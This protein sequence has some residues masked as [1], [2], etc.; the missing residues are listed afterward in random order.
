MTPAI[1]E[2]TVARRGVAGVLAAA[3]ITTLESLALERRRL[4]WLAGRVAAKRAV[5]SLCRRR[6]QRVP[7]YSAIET[8]NDATGA[9]HFTI[10]GQPELAERLSVSIAHTDGTAVAA[11]AELAASGTVG[12]DI[13]STRPLDLALVRRVLT[14]I[15]I[16]QLEWVAAEHPSPIAMWT[17]K[18]AALK[19]ARHLCSALRDIELD[20]R[21]ARTLGAR[22]VG[23]HV[24][25]H[26]IIVRHRVVGPFTVA[27]ALC[28]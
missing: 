6:A 7:A 8:R 11:V 17:A 25:D 10:H 12:V 18:E 19:A 27:I 21:H 20:W 22:V 15:E 26:T 9:P 13:E 23:T 5:R 16:A 2:R 4:D 24:P 14:E 3:E 1:V 28:Q